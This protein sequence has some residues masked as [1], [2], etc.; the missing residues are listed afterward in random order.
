MQIYPAQI[1]LYAVCLTRCSSVILEAPLLPKKFDV[2]FCGNISI[3]YLIFRW[4]SLFTSKHNYSVF[5]ILLFIYFD[6]PRIAINHIQ[7]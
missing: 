7:Y 6:F 3:E 5:V 4:Y 2:L 1:R